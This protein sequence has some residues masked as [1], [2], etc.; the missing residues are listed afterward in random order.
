[1]YTCMCVCMTCERETQRL[2]R[3]EMKGERDR[4]PGQQNRSAIDQVRVGK[5]G[6]WVQAL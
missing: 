2:V 1:M 4:V 3:S 5:G 6:K